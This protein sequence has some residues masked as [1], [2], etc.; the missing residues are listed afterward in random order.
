MY[1]QLFYLL[2]YLLAWHTKYGS[3]SSKYWQ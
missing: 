1:F 3:I 2:L